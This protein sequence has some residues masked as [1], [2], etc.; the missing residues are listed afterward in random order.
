M[1]METAQGTDAGGIGNEQAELE[2]VALL[3]MSDTVAAIMCVLRRI[4]SGSG[5][6]YSTTASAALVNLATNYHRLGLT[7]S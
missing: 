4:Y 2:I 7:V 6:G 5:N 1:P 3:E